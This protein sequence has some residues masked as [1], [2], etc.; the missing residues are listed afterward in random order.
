[1]SCT[2][3]CVVHR[4]FLYFNLSIFKIKITLDDNNHMHRVCSELND[5][6]KQSF[7][8]NPKIIRELSIE[9]DFF[10]YQRH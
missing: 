1:M 3:F 2:H 4:R 7:L 6:K 10:L 5:I 8:Q 9:I